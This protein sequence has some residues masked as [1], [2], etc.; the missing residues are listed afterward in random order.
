MAASVRAPA[1]AAPPRPA[2]PPP[3]RRLGARRRALPPA[4]AAGPPS[5]TLYD[6]HDRLVPYEQAWAWQRALVAA[7]AARRA[8]DS[9][10]SDAP[11]VSSAGALLLLQH[12]PVYTLGAGATT[13]HL[14]FDPAAPPAGATLHRVERG[15]EV[16]FH[17]PGQLVAYPI[18]DLRALRPDL[19]WLLRSLEGAVIRCAVAARLRFWSLVLLLCLIFI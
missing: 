16:T 1:S 2:P 5:V 11:A 14:R 6:L 12:P 19:H 4:A 7:V 13:A 8:S 18:L 9:V 3:R 15:G 10:A 17:G